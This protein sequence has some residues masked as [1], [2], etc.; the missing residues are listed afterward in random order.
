M[1]VSLAR[2]RIQ[3]EIEKLKTNDRVTGLEVFTAKTNPHHAIMCITGAEN[4]P[5]ANGKFYI[6]FFFPDEYPSVPPKARFLTKIYHPNIDKIGRI[7]LDTLKDQWSAALQL[8]TLGL[9]IMGLL[10][11]PNCDDPLDQAVASKFRNDRKEAER[12]AT[13]YTIMYAHDDQKLKEKLGIDYA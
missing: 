5:Y 8:R 12:I 4:T 13:E 10:S 6:E 9:S 2:K 1:S 7:C 3:K 11:Q